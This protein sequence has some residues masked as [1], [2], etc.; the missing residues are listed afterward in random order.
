MGIVTGHGA[1]PL[2]QGLRLT[3]VL[4]VAAVSVGNTP[5]CP[6]SALILKDWFSHNLDKL[7]LSDDDQPLSILD[8]PGEDLGK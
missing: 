5:P 6:A 4:F 3:T 1:T 7:G 2:T 8:P